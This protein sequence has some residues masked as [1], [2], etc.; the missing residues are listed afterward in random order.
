MEKRPISPEEANR[1]AD[2]IKK[3]TSDIKEGE[4]VK[5]PIGSDF[6]ISERIDEEGEG[7]IISER[8]IQVKILTI[9]YDQV[10]VELL[11]D[12]DGRAT[13][14]STAWVARQF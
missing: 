9:E 14:G 5:L 1:L 12:L 4:E 2:R 6:F 8:P 13:K 10:R 11:E 7:H 3:E